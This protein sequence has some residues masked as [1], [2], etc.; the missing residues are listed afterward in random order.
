MYMYIIMCAPLVNGVNDHSVVPGRYLDEG[1][2]PSHQL[3]VVLQNEVLRAHFHQG[4]I[5]VLQRGV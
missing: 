2:W 4:D 1:Q 3:V 5:G